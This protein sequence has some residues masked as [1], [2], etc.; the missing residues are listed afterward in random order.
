MLDKALGGLSDRSQ[1]AVRS[2]FGIGRDAPEKL[3]EIAAR[4]GL[5]NKQGAFGIIKTALEKIKNKLPAKAYD[6]AAES[7]AMAVAVGTI[8]TAKGVYIIP[9]VVNPDLLARAC[10]RLKVPCY[11]LRVCFSGLIVVIENDNM[12]ADEILILLFLLLSF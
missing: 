12:L 3:H 2:Y 6:F 8:Q 7:L 4:Y 9:N 1:D 10:N 5:K 11:N